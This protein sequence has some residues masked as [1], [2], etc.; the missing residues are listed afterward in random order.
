MK[1][2]TLKKTF[3]SYI[4]FTILI[5]TVFIS[6]LYVYLNYH[7]ELK[8]WDAIINNLIKNSIPIYD[9]YLW[10][11]DYENLKKVSDSLLLGTPFLCK[12]SV[13]NEFK[14]TIY[15]KF[16]QDSFCNDKS[17]L[18]IIGKK[19]FHNKK[20]IGSV[21]FLISKTPFI[22]DIYT[23]ILLSLIIIITLVS[24]IF[25]ILFLTF[26]K[27]VEAPIEQITSNLSKISNG[28]YDI[29]IKKT[30]FVEFDKIVDSLNSM[31]NEI[32]IRKKNNF[33]LIERLNT[34]INNIPEGII[35]LDKNGDYAEINDS[36]AK[37]LNQ[38]KE[39]ILSSQIDEY[40]SSKYNIKKGF[41]I[42]NEIFVTGYKEFE[43][44]LIDS[45]GKLIPV[46][47]KG[48]KILLD[49][50]EFVIFS[51]TDISY[52][53]NLEQELL[54]KEKLESLGN[55]AGGIAHD[56][57]NILLSVIG[58]IELSIMFL[59]KGNYEK[60]N[61]KLEKTLK[62]IERAK[63]LTNQ[64]LTFSKG[65]APV[66]EPYLNLKKLIEDT[67]NFTLTGSSVEVEFDFDNNLHP[68]KI[69]SGQISQVIQN[70]VSNAREA[71]NNKGKLEVKAVNFLDYVKISI[72]DYGKGIP[73]EIL[74]KIWEPYF[75]TK[76]GNNGLGLSIVYSIIKNHNGKVKIFTKEGEFSEFQIFIPVLHEYEKKDYKEKTDFNEI[77][78]NAPQQKLNILIMDDDEEI[79]DIFKNILESMGHEVDMANNGEEVIE[80]YK[81]NMFDIVFLDLTVKGGMGGKECIEKLKEMDKNVFAVVCSGYSNDPVM[82]NYEEYGFKNILKKPF[83]LKDLKNIISSY[84]IQK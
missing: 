9:N 28:N 66:K 15:D 49:N 84:I 67:V 40:S 76:S 68:V 72:K 11:L 34:L 60:V 30:D 2:K 81:K 77:I 7:K 45:T 6:T 21:E 37:I 48:R 19:F 63:G 75:T 10:T 80:K 1:N 74:E 5:V 18:E 57:N 26:E 29:K 46:F 39:D 20:F 64:L 82:N 71:M 38:D 52:I 53:K 65:G 55:L 3:F 54:K 47:V 58:N 4:L 36:F 78:V 8:K 44:E 50:D 24:L 69:D 79:K 17:K 13:Q 73:K 62:N 61:E 14:K 43:W 12:I 25:L 83:N 31:L 35:I 56:F 27:F 33:D 23:L 70:I 22:N 51:I 32:R 16:R 41:N 42:L 59:N